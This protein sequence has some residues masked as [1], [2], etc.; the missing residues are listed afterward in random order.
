MAVHHTLR[1]AARQGGVSVAARLAIA[2]AAGALVHGNAMAQ[3]APGA[4]QPQPV[5][6]KPPT[7]ATR[8]ANQ[9][10]LGQLPFKDRQDFEDAQRGL[11][12]RPDPAAMR[13]AYGNVGASVAALTAQVGNDKP[14]PDTVNPSLWRNA[15]LLGNYGLYK[16]TDRIYQVRGLELANMTLIQGDTGW[17]VLDSL[18]SAEAARAA[19]DLVTQHLGRR[20]VVA[21]VVS[22]SHVDHYGGIR[23]IVDEADV[24]AGKVRIIAP[25]GFMEEAV[26]ENVI[27]G[28]AMSRRSVYMGGASLPINPQGRLAGG[29]GILG[30]PGTVTLLSPT[31]TIA[32]DGQE[33]VIDGVKMVF[34]LTPG[35]EAPAE[36]NTWF[37]QFKAMWMAENTTNTLHN[38]LTLRGA[39]VRDATKWVDGINA[40][41]ASFG[42]DVEVKF[43][44]HHWPLWGHDRIIDYFEKQRDLYKYIHDQSV[45]LMNEGYVGTEIAEVVKLPPE[46]AN[47]W[48]N[49]GYWGTV[50]HNTRAVYQRYLGWYDSNPSSLDPLPPVPAAK[51]YVEYMGGEAAILARAHKDFD[52]G[53]Y[54]WLAEALRQVVYANPDNKEARELLADSYEQ[55]GYQAEAPTWRAEYLQGAY[56][57]RNGVPNARRVQT[58]SPDTVQAMPPEMLFNYMA[59]RLNGPKAAGKHLVLNVGLTDLNQ[60]YALE[61]K[62]GVLN[63][64]PKA[65][66]KADVSLKL[67]KTVLERLQRKD[68]TVDQAVASGD[69]VLSGRRDALEQLLA[70]LD[71]Y[72]S[73]F[74]VV[75]PNPDPS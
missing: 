75:T 66:P 5:A 39:Q 73:W 20:P 12:A 3:A 52:K 6:P 28:N 40:T 63:Y 14:A 34:Q 1:R 41:I 64:F 16:V 61:V 24:K 10:V 2:L 31:D 8:A 7:A 44:S 58:A 53:E 13:A 70:M 23:G 49:R 11:I 15:Q 50:K 67:S 43:Q 55:L 54:R 26:S 19:F 4:G 35:T 71:T 36:M 62:H 72:P 47:F 60:Q 46:L 27:A 25:E 38:L 56:E 30:A 68:L 9:A 33:M 29:L 21:V 22:H 57:L 74:K 32:K 48:P 65:T 42:K 51:K 18:T 59:V 69:L 17:I 45:R 37:P